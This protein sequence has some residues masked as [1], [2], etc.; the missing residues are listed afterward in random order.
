MKTCSKI[1]LLFLI[2]CLAIANL[3]EH[4][5]AASRETNVSGVSQQQQYEH[6]FV[7]G[8]MQ[9]YIDACGNFDTIVPPIPKPEDGATSYADGYAA[10]K[11]QGQK[12]GDENCPEE[13]DQ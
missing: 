5:V 2:V 13:E 7:A 12:D 8:C 9:A 4:R 1:F 3:F 6:G 10:G 11:T